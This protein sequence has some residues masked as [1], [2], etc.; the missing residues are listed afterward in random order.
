MSELY[1]G[2]SLHGALVSLSFGKPVV[3]FSP[4]KN[5][6]HIGVLTE[7][8]LQICRVSHPNNIPES[9]IMLLNMPKSWF[10]E[11]SRLAK[12]RIDQY[13]D[14]FSD[15]IRNRKNSSIPP[16]WSQD[17]TTGEIRCKSV[18][19]FRKLTQ[20]CLVKKQE[21]NFVKRCLHYIIRKSHTI[22]ARYDRLMFWLRENGFISH[23]DTR[24]YREMCED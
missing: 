21:I 16:D 5:G 10:A 20:L 13:Y 2:T 4:S 23:L 22:G 12:V 24:S 3:S 14:Q 11:K 6:K 1:I 15:V 8:G 18:D 19:G 7:L 17:P 9:A